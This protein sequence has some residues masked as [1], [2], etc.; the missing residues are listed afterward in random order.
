MQALKQITVALGL[1]LAATVSMSA[2]ASAHSSHDPAAKGDLARMAGVAHAVFQG[3]VTK[4]AYRTAAGANG[5][6]YTF[7]TYAV[8]K[9]MQG[10]VGR[11]ITLR[12]IGGHDGR[13]TFVEASGVPRFEEG[14]EDIMFLAGNGEQGCALVLCENGRFRIK[15]GQVHNGTGQP[16]VAVASGKAEAKGEGHPAFDTFRYPA[17]T[18]DDL[19]KNPQAAAQLARSGM[20]VAQAKARFDAEAPKQLEIRSVKLQKGAGEG[21]AAGLSAPSAPALA[22]M[23]VGSFVVQFDSVAGAQSRGKSTPVRSADV[24]GALSSPRM[25]AAAPPSM[26]QEPA[27]AMS[28]DDEAD[29]RAA[30]AAR[31]EII[32][33]H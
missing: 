2:I 31:N 30:P 8:S 6:P 11:E 24:N 10:A 32:R 33:K 17:P 9:V 22:G 25:V 27:R 15:D 4:V 18:F 3:K 5:M 1:T 12:F 14:D 26:P 23:E 7:V 21:G 16:I 13:G 19:M 28:Q 20:T 29:R